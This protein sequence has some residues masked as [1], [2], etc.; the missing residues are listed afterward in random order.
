MSWQAARLN[1]D[2]LPIPAKS[3]FNGLLQS[4]SGECCLKSSI[5]KIEDRLPGHPQTRLTKHELLKFLK[6]DFCT[7]R[8]DAFSPSLWVVATQDS[9]HISSLTH[10]VVR[11]HE[12]T[13]TE[14]PELHLVW[15]DK[16]VFVKPLPP[17]LLSNVFWE[18][19]LAADSE[20][21]GVH[22]ALLGFMRSY[23]YLIQHPSDFELAVEKRLVP[24]DCNHPKID[25]AT[26][27][28]FMEQFDVVDS[29]VS[30]RFHYGDLRL[31]RLNFW[32]KF[33]LG[34]FNFSDAY[35]NYDAYFSRFYGPVLFLFGVL[36][37]MISSIQ[38]GF[39]SQKGLQTV[40]SAW[41][42]LYKVG[43]GLSVAVLVLACFIAVSLFALFVYL[44]LNEYIFALRA[45]VRIRR[46]GRRRKSV[47]DGDK[48]GPQNK[49]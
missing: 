33:V 2:R 26:F 16:R 44:L 34:E 4:N 48:R 18:V 12:I 36:S 10:Q 22:R 40:H 47:E 15:H 42:P 32:A 6:E 46:K 35:G 20:S 45:L 30:L 17:F 14:N 25:F 41:R 49:S 5:N 28:L 27:V 11:G 9:R 29:D 39:A 43:E 21:E 3:L 23:R 31:S 7:P 1:G 13:L 24:V 37:I 8:L 38:L 19:C